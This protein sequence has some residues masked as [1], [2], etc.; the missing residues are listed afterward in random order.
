[1]LFVCLVAMT[2]CRAQYARDPEAAHAFASLADPRALRSVVKP[3]ALPRHARNWRS[4][5]A[6]FHDMIWRTTTR[7]ISASRS[8]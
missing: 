3:A 5:D 6:T 7:M 1:M 2:F 8:L 4:H